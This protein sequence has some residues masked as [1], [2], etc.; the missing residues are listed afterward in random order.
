MMGMTLKNSMGFGKS[1]CY[2]C[3]KRTVTCHSECEDYLEEARMRREKT[4][5]AHRQR[6]ADNAVSEVLLSGV[7]KIRKKT[8]EN[9]VR[10]R[11]WY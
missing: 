9:R 4:E 6:V 11:K 2:G 3:E 8:I 10:K 5:N 7:T 1:V